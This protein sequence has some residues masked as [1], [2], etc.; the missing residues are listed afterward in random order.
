VKCA[1]LLM[2]LLAGCH[3]LRGDVI[4]YRHER[5]DSKTYS[6]GQQTLKMRCPIEITPTIEREGE[7]ITV[8]CPEAAK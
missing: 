8:R 3:C 4:E 1:V 7:T 5:T 2:P 6:R